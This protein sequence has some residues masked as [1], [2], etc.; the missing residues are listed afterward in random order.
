MVESN[1]QAMSERHESSMR[2]HEA[3]A[4]RHE[5]AAALWDTRHEARR[6]EFE[7]RCARIE[8]EAAQLERLRTTGL[9]R[10]DA[11]VC[12]EID[13]LTGEIERRST[14]LRADDAALEQERA[15][16]RPQH[17]GRGHGRT[18]RAAKPPVR[19][20]AVAA[21]PERGESDAVADALGAAR[22]VAAQMRANARH[23]SSV[24][25]QTANVLETSAAL[26]QA[27]AER[28]EGAGRAEAGAEERRAADRAYAAARS[29]RLQANEWL[30]FAL[31]QAQ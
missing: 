26:A 5:A 3:S 22:R 13:R 19:R 28:L 14:R 17:D 15:R 31:G 6:A 23:L 27:H 8:R 12:A 2:L 10:P 4:Q 9:A 30:K 16:P 21:E 25:G 7:R 18:A 24:L 20:D 11:A 1:L 29:A